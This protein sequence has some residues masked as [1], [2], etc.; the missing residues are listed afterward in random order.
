MR[1]G[2]VLHIWFYGLVTAYNIAK[3]SFSTQRIIFSWVYLKVNI[4]NIYIY[5]FGIF[6]DPTLRTS[7]SVE[8]THPEFPHGQTTEALAKT[9]CPMPTLKAIQKL[10]SN[11]RRHHQHSHPQL[12]LVGQRVVVVVV[13]VVAVLVSVLV[14]V[15]AAARNHPYEAL[16][17]YSS[18]VGLPLICKAGLLRQWS[19]NTAVWKETNMHV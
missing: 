3:F 19:R 4:Q 9:Y 13:V 6:S 17:T 5:G 8:L 10:N 15:A 18:I 1:W 11:H 14:V 16:P 7:A 2:S 12:V